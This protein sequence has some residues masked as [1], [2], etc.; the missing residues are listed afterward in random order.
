[1]TATHDDIMAEIAASKAA[2]Q[3][4]RQEV[5]DKLA[6]IHGDIESIKASQQK[7]VELLE[8]FAAV[9]TGGR[10]IA[11]LSKFVAGLIAL[12]VLMKGGAQFLVEFG[13]K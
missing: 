13:S 2:L 1:M 4:M 8:A 11:W 6:P 9:K 10:F 12:Y 3:A 7:T 5:D